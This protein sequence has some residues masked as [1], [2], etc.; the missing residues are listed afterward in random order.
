[1]NNLEL[2]TQLTAIFKSRN[3]GP[4][5]FIGS[6]FSRRYLGLCDWKSLLEKYCIFGKPFE[7]Y[8]ALVTLLIQLLQDLLQ[9]TLIKNGGR[10]LVLQIAGK[11]TIRR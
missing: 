10:M 3:A 2:K 9:K 11:S 8:L 1:M 6:G 5:L 4:F 7:Y